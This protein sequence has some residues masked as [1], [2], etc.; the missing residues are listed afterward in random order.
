MN[1][2]DQQQ[3]PDDSYGQLSRIQP[4]SQFARYTK[5]PQQNFSFSFNSH[6][7]EGNEVLHISV[8]A[9]G[10]SNTIHD[11]LVLVRKFQF[12]SLGLTAVHKSGNSLT[13]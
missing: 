7:S 8:S 1:S 2:G 12:A 11:R 6:E 9:A 13:M 5:S 4:R 3:L 10:K